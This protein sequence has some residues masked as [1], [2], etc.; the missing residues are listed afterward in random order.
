MA[1][2]KHPRKFDEAFKRQI[3]QLY[4]GG[5]SPADYDAQG[6]FMQANL[7]FHFAQRLRGMCAARPLARRCCGMVL[8][9]ALAASLVGVAP[10]AAYASDENVAAAWVE[11]VGAESDDETYQPYSY[12][13]SVSAE[14]AVASIG[15]DENGLASSPYPEKFDL[16]DPN[17]DGDRSDS[18]VTPVKQQNPW[19]TCWG[20]AVIAASETS[21]LSELG[22][23]YKETGLDLSEL[24]LV[25]SVFRNT[26]APEKFVGPTQAGEGYHN[27][28]KNPNAGLDAGGFAT[29]GS[30]IFA[31]GIGPLMESDV[32]YR[33]A[34]GL[35]K[36]KVERETG[37]EYSNLTEGQI[38]DLRASGLT[39]VELQWAGNYS[40]DGKTMLYTDWSV[41][42]DLWNQS[43][44]EFESG[45]ILPS[46]TSYDSE[47]NTQYGDARVIEAMK[48][49]LYDFGRGISISVNVDSYLNRFTWSNYAYTQDAANHAVTIVGWDD[50]Y[51]KENFSNDSGILPEGDGAWLVKNSWGSETEDFPNS[52][53]DPWGIEENGKSTGYFWLSYYDRVARNAETFDF[54][55]NVYGSNDEYYIDEYDYLPDSSTYILGF[56]TPVSSANIFTAEGDMSLRTLGSA[57]YRPNS[58]V[59][60]EVYLLD[61]EAAS[62]TDSN[63]ATLAYSLDDTYRYGGYHRVTLPETDWIAMRAGQRY[64][65][66]TTQ[67]CNDNGY[68]YQGVATNTERRSEA[69][70]EKFR[71][72]EQQ[73]L[74]E[75]YYGSYYRAA[76]QEL[77]AQGASEE[78]A[79]SKADEQAKRELEQSEP[80][81]VARV[82]ELVD[83]YANRYFVARVNEGESWTS[84]ARTD[85]VSADDAENVQDSVES[86]EAPVSEETAWTDWTVVAKAL[87]ESYGVMADNLSIKAIS[88]MRSWASVDELS[89]LKAAIASAKNV[90]AQAKIS[91]D[92]SDVS[93]SNTWLTQEERDSLASAIDDAE[94][95]LALA[96][97][98]YETKLANTTPSSEDVNAAVAAI[99]FD[100]HR[101]T[102]WANGEDPSQAID[103]ESGAAGADASAL[104]ESAGASKMPQSGDSADS[105]LAAAMLAAFAAGALVVAARRRMV[106]RSKG[107]RRRGSGEF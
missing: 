58:T 70:V 86:A 10:T 45:N 16:R 3:V 46:L 42:E 64:A 77:I 100:A 32:S 93:E 29:Y 39:V 105:A 1:D 65:V 41:S 52:Q 5:K 81:I 72:A 33:N 60:Y 23:T 94:A 53:N 8:S 73:N 55:V 98:D 61:D 37:D 91:A 57:T 104:G 101:G 38:A 82:D 69:E 28:S 97:S 66:V 84:A 80:D 13:T 7:N 9:A 44:Y 74:E 96:G 103:H 51:S 34:E 48:S 15:E 88:E 26:G 68:Y 40:E 22:K 4:E 11:A 89:S 63:H 49:E 17:G 56:E 6:D 92:G 18:V 107:A 79:K 78:E 54:D 62:P 30:S 12:A 102:K 35:I 2:P 95:M 43:Y 25:G 99:S 14:A 27:S 24:Q 76:Y 75:S 50:T 31:A 87:K 47:G 20:F 83:E 106:G 36:C 71:A 90:L 85:W 59:T 67:K 21:I 19:S